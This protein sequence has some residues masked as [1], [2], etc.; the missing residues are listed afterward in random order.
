MTSTDTEF[1]RRVSRIPPQG[2]GLSVDVYSPDL[3]ELMEELDR[4][5]LD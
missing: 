2:L 5:R 3:F 4:R 1:L